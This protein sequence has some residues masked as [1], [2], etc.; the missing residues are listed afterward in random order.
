MN[1]QLQ[2]A[3]LALFALVFDDRIACSQT[4]GDFKL[5]HRSSFVNQPAHNPFWPIGWVKSDQ[6]QETSQDT[7]VS[8]NPENFVVTSISLSATPLAVINGKAFAEGETINA[9][10]GGQRIRIQVLS[11]G[12]GTVTLQYAGKK[13]MLSLKRASSGAKQEAKE[14]AP[15]DN[16]MILH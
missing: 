4:A 9:I 1:K 13:I 12:D 5:Q 15:H 14:T 8:I 3:G 7:Q 2:I 10:Y 6:P 11:I 16:A